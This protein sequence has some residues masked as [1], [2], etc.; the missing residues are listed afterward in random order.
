MENYIYIEKVSLLKK[1]IGNLCLISGLFSLIIINVKIGP[2]YIFLWVFLC[3]VGV[4]FIS[5]EGFEINFNKNSYRKI[6]SMYGINY[7]LSW[8]NYP[9]IKYFSL[10]ET[11][12]RQTIGGRTFN[13]TATATL[14]SKMVKINIFDE[15]NKHKTLY[16]ANN[17]K[18]AI[19]IGERIQKAYNVEMKQNFE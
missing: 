12:I 13:S 16:I 8:K 15:N 11:N 10:V 17:R 4:F 1:I 14:S 9:R 6:I 18:E 19:E 2:Q 3:F 5:T 7:G